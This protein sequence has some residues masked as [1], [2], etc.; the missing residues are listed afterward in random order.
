MSVQGPRG[1][2]FEQFVLFGYLCGG[3]SQARLVQNPGIN[4]ARLIRP[5]CTSSLAP[6]IHSTRICSGASP[7]PTA[8][9]RAAPR[10][11]VCRAFPQTLPLPSPIS[12]PSVSSPS[13][14]GVELSLSHL[15]LLSNSPS[16][17]RDLPLS[18]PLASV[19]TAELSLSP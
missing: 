7:H 9:A 12:T 8:F 5:I 15:H 17:P 6:H 14:V 18:S 19:A 2:K 11:R 3:R 1:A 10:A 4:Q 13:L 16:L